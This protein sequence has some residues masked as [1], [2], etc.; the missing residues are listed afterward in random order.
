MRVAII[1]GSGKMGQWF[2]SF[3]LKDGKEVIITGRNEKKLLEA[4]EQLGVEVTTNNTEAVK[5]AD[6]VL[7]SVTID[8]FKEVVKQ[9]QPHLN[10]NY[11]LDTTNKVC[12]TGCIK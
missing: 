2:A 3:L 9:L 5:G 10:G 1:G 8:S 4:K 7:F 12:Y 11:I 6:V